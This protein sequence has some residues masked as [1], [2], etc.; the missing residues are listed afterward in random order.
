[1]LFTAFDA[2]SPT[3]KVSFWTDSV[4]LIR[5]VAFP[6]GKDVS[7]VV[8]ADLKDEIFI[9]EEEGQRLRLVLAE[10]DQCAELDGEQVEV[11]LSS[12]EVFDLARRLR[13]SGDD[14]ALITIQLCGGSG[15]S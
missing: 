10:E 9:S 12:A 3:K 15:D 4:L 14:G 11:K 7:K 8:V 13:E 6:Q 1:M 2:L 5:D